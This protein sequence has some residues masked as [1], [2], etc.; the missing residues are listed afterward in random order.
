MLR[1]AWIPHQRERLLGLVDRAGL[2]IAARQAGERVDVGIVLLEELRI[3]VSRAGG[4][5]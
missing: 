5:A 4:I 3:E 1:C 2:D